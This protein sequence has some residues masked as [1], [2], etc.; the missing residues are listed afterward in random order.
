[1]THLSGP[2][3]MS[4]IGDRRTVSLASQEPHILVSHSVG[5]GNRQQDVQNEG[6]AGLQPSLDA[7]GQANE[8]E[9]ECANTHLYNWFPGKFKLQ[10]KHLL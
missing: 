2:A 9:K 1:M 7:Q 10:H 6:K 4:T 5:H 8:K 3:F